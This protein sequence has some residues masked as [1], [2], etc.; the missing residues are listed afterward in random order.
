MRCP[1]LAMSRSNRQ[2]IAF[3]RVIKYNKIFLASSSSLMCS[4]YSSHSNAFESCGI[5]RNIVFIH[6]LLT[7]TLTHKDTEREKQNEKITDN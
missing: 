3:V 2:G 5:V 7:D 4:S 6:H 1:N